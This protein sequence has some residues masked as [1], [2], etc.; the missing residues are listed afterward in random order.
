MISK[1]VMCCMKAKNVRLRPYQLLCGAL[2]FAVIFFVSSDDDI[3]LQP[4]KIRT[5]QTPTTGQNR[6][7]PRILHQSYKDEQIPEQYWKSIRSWR[8]KHP[9][10]I[11]M[12][13]TDSDIENF[14]RKEY[15]DFKPLFDSYTHNLQRV[16]AVRYFILYHYGGIYADMDVDALRPL[17]SLIARYSCILSRERYEQTMFL[18]SKKEAI[19]NCVMAA[20]PRHPFMKFVI[21]KLYSYLPDSLTTTYH[22]MIGSFNYILYST[23]PFAL[24]SIF[25]QYKPCNRVTTPCDVYLA[26]P[27][28]LL[29][30]INKIEISKMMRYCKSWY[31]MPLRLSFSWKRQACNQLKAVNFRNSVSNASYTNHAFSNLGYSSA[32]ASRRRSKHIKSLVRNYRRYCETKN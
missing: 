12:L 16:D 31:F 9:D 19:M 3:Q 20:E 25:Y 22:N 2:I 18:W 32:K 27:E 4:T 26:E 29:P 8:K 7:I 14:I 24:S 13:W 5:L 1:V 23:G 21:S 30:T 6:T 11:Y 10:F 17:D 15:P 28:E